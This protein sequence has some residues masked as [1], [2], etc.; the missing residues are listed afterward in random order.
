MATRRGLQMA[1]RS[2]YAH[3]TISRQ[4]LFQADAIKRE[5]ATVV[6]AVEFDIQLL[7]ASEW[8]LAEIAN[9]NFMRSTPTV[10]S[11]IPGI[12]HWVEKRT[13]ETLLG[14]VLEERTPP[15]YLVRFDGC[16]RNAIRYPSSIA[17]TLRWLAPHSVCSGA[18][19]V[20]YAREGICLE[21]AIA[22]DAGNEVEFS[23]LDRDT[24]R[25]ATG[26]VRWSMNQGDGYLTGVELTNDLGYAI[27]G[28]PA[29]TNRN[30]RI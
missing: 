11:S 24:N 18:T 1:R 25:T 26:I 5:R 16:R 10:E 12:V 21:S 7:V 19:I 17:G 15:E 6:E 23:W 20:N 22:P 9:V 2:N 28:I 30:H 29:L 27:T 3:V 4:S 14:I 13:S 8:S